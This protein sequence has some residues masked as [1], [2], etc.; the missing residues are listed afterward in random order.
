MLLEQKSASG[1]VSSGSG[2]AY[3]IP[4]PIFGN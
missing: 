2:Y 3:H 1:S 4:D